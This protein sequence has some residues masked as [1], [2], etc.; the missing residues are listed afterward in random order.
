MK[1]L[2]RTYLFL[3]VFSAPLAVFAQG[4]P[5]SPLVLNSTGYDTRGSGVP[6]NSSSTVL[7]FTL[8]GDT[9]GL[10]AFDV[11]TSDS[12]VAVSLI[13]P[14][15][16]EVTSANASGLG[17]TFTII[18][19]N[20]SSDEVPSVLALPGTHTLIQIPG[21]QP[22][23]VYNIKANATRLRWAQHP[24]SLQRTFH[25]RRCAPR[26]PRIPPTTRLEI[27]WSS[28]RLCSIQ[29]APS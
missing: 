5:N 9:T 24:E 15:G 2:Q 21:G 6:A 10:N 20:A 22:S 12:G 17:F 8:E 27:R 19:E 1:I 28:Q 26:H 4:V 29:P 14:S 13:L 16:T 7:S 25:L 18:P 23:G 3:V 11:A